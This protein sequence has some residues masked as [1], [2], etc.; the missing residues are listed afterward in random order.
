MLLFETMDD[1]MFRR[2]LMFS[3]W[4]AKYICNVI[5]K[6]YIFEAMTIYTYRFRAIQ[7]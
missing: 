5:G 3:L 7:T 4:T 6:L 2:M 1:A